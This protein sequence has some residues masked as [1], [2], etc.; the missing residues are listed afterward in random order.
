MTKQHIVQQGFR[1][2]KDIWHKGVQIIIFVIVAFK[3]KKIHKKL[4]HD[5]MLEF[6]KYLQFHHF[7][8]TR[9]YHL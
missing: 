9:W 1:N 8:P 4:T 6:L 7:A 2:T 5:N 3:L